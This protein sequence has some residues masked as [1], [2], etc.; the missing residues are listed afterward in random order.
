L[1]TPIP[2]LELDPEVLCTRGCQRVATF[3]VDTGDV[4]DGSPVTEL[5]CAPCTDDLA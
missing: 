4:V 3:A 1:T 5:R 2:V